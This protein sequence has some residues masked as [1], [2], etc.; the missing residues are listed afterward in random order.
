MYG[1]RGDRLPV[2]SRRFRAQLATAAS[3]H[4]PTGECLRKEL[5]E[6]SREGC[7]Q[8]PCYTRCALEQVGL[9]GVQFRGFAFQVEMTYLA[10][11]RGLRI[12]E[13]PIVFVD[14]H[15]GRSKADLSVVIEMLF[16]PW[17][18]RLHALG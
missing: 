4:K 11:R 14:R 12:V 10:H 16:Q 2:L 6:S 1:G 9:S 13:V 3:R 18:L 7:N 15:L 5:A 17:R 8:R